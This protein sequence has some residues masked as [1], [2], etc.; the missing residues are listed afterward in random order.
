MDGLIDSIIAF[1]EDLKTLGPAGKLGVL[2][3]LVG[4][5]SVTW[6]VVRSRTKSRLHDY[7]KEGEELRA[8]ISERDKII[9]DLRHEVESWQGSHPDVLLREIER[10]EK[11]RNEDL[12]VQKSDVLFGNLREPLLKA[13]RLLA[14]H[15][16]ARAA[17]PARWP[18]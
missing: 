4:L 11:D 8:Q 5:V 13:C 17:G 18:A 14:G 7:I 1:L 6:A 2:G 10:E 9:K 3:G 15:H 16:L 12:A